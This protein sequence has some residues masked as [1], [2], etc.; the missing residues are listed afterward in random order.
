MSDAD[1][2]LIVKWIVATLCAIVLGMMFAL[3]IGL[4]DP[5]VDNKEIFKIISPAFSGVVGGLLGFVGGLKVNAA[6]KD[7]QDEVL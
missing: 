4:F 7:K 1:F 2:S 5:L 6:K 3:M